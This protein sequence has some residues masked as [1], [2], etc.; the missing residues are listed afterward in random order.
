MVGPVS[1]EDDLK[2]L[3]AYF[4][5]LQMEELNEVLGV[6]LAAMRSRETDAMRRDVI[7]KSKSLRLNKPLQRPEDKP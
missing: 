5:S 4:Q 2:Q 1:F 3:G 6:V 7:T